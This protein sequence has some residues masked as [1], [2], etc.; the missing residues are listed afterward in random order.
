MFDKLNMRTD[1]AL[2]IAEVSKVTE[3]EGFYVEETTGKGITVTRVRITEASAEEKYGK[4]R[5][6]YVTVDLSGAFSDTEA[7]TAAVE[8]TAKEI[9]DLLYRNTVNRESASVLVVGLGNSSMSSDAVGPKTAESVLVTRHIKEYMPE[10]F[11]SL[12][13]SN[14]SAIIPGVLGQTGIESADIIKAAIAKTSPDAVLVIDALASQMMKRLCTVVQITDTGITP[15]SGVGNDRAELS[16]KTLG[17]PVVAI[18]IPTVVDTLTLAAELIR[19]AVSELE[20]KYGS[21]AAYGRF[22]SEISDSVSEDGLGLVVTPKDIDRSVVKC[23][24]LLSLAINKALH[25]GL[26]QEEINALLDL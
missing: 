1:L 15:G 14:V 17:V 16:Q 18:G 4:A 20:D 13:L 8:T 5:G 9:S 7:H 3:D 19:S 10:L 26:E 6:N 2:D 23:A 25:Y 12:K 11:E 21:D 24:R 22:V